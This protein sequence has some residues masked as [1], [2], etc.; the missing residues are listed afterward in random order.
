MINKT[1]FEQLLKQV[2]VKLTGASE[3]GIKGELYDVL[4]E[5]LND[6]SIW[7]Q[8]VTVPYEA[9][10]IS[11][12]LT[13]S[14]GQ[15]IRLSGVLDWG[16]T[17]PVD[18]IQPPNGTAFVP[19]LMPDIGT[20]ILKNPPNTSGYMEATVVCNTALPTDRHMIPD[21]PDW[22]L[23]IWHVGILDGVLGK[24]MTSPNKSYSDKVQGI[25]HLKRFRD[26]IGRARTSKLRANTNGAS[27]W[28]FPQQFR[29]MSQQSGVPAIG[30]ANER[31]F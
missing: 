26:A 10:V 22:L 8:S 2:Q 28:R 25:Y 19:A 20:L 5:F 15:I 13:V 11:Y 6:T 4:S 16:T 12:P 7:T 31:S 24:M 27:A 9:N 30:S 21:A 1:D 17:V 14:E 18:N 29:S 3:S 23:P